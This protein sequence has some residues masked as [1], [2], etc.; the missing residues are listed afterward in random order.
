[1]SYQVK[2]I[3]FDQFSRIW[4]VVE[5][6]TRLKVP[7]GTQGGPEWTFHRFLMILG[8]PLEAIGHP[9][10]PFSTPEPTREGNG[11]VKTMKN[12]HHVAQVAYGSI[13]NAF[14]AAP[15]LLFIVKN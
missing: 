10:A 11:E 7:L 6:V 9:W 2:S 3:Y 8:T 1:M 15:D 5:G 13:P 14:G 12:D 4:V